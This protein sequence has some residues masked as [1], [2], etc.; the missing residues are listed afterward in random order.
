MNS[1]N[2]LGDIPKWL[3]ECKAAVAVKRLAARLYRSK[4]AN[5][6][7][8]VVIILLSFA[9]VYLCSYVTPYMDD[10]LN[11]LHIIEMGEPLYCASEPIGS[12]SDIFV[13]QYNHYLSINGRMIAHL[14]L[15]IILYLFS[16]PI[17]DLITTVCIILLSLLLAHLRSF[18]Y[19]DKRLSKTDYCYSFALLS[20][21]NPRIDH[22]FFNTTCCFNYTV[23]ILIVLGFF[24]LCLP[25][26][27]D[28]EVKLKT[29]V[30]SAYSA[31]M[32]LLGII[33]GWTNENIGPSLFCALVFI[34]VYRKVCFGKRSPIYA[35]TSAVGSLLGSMALILAPGNFIRMSAVAD[36][37][38]QYGGIMKLFIRAYYM[39]RAVFNYL[40]PAVVALVSLLLI[41]RLFIKKKLPIQTIGFI[42]WAV[43]SVLAMILSPSYPE[44]AAF[45]NL[46]L[47]LIPVLSLLS[48][49][50]G[51]SRRANK[52][53]VFIGAL[54]FLGALAQ[55][56][57]MSLYTIM[58]V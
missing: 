11:Y 15:Q 32:L 16:E 2:F 50:R 24:R 10:D 6:I 23:T 28:R 37:N 41:N 33:A 22:T 52:Y 46:A 20:L 40:F 44:R 57:T 27:E 45:G 25:L 34:I 55:L 30:D 54:L 43:I 35:Y 4:R 38:E 42:I 17:V 12:M 13:S 56:F 18:G 58:K 7:A 36:K 49:I 29:G 26:L 21:I 53:I 5:T 1:A 31:L 3:S 8:W 39:E 14:P 19:E 48:V 47:M 51:S 9:A